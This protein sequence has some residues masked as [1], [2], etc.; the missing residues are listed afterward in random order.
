MTTEPTT[1]QYGPWEHDPYEPSQYVRHKTAPDGSL[2]ADYLDL[3]HLNAIEDCRTALEQIAMANHP[4]PRYLYKGEHGPEA[5][6][7]VELARAVMRK[8]WASSDTKDTGSP[9]TV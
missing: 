9:A 8:H 5:L 2:I 7:A 1:K 3:D 6:T 4:D